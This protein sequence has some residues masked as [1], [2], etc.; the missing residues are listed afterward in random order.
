M[1]LSKI[2][3]RIGEFVLLLKDSR[4]YPACTFNGSDTVTL[5]WD[6]VVKLKK[7][8]EELFPNNTYEIYKLIK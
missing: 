8:L 3:E 4:D 7:G 5:D 1:E 6:M 2:N